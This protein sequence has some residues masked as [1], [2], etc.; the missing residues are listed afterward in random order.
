MWD[1]RLWKNSAYTLKRY[2][3]ALKAVAAMYYH[4]LEFVDN[5]NNISDVFQIRP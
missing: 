3:D 4:R 2:D 1:H 5:F